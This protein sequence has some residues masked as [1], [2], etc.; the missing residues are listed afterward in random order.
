MLTAFGV[1][2]VKIYKSFAELYFII[3][4]LMNKNFSDERRN[5]P[6]ICLRTFPK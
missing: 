6:L 4:N 1:L 2:S 3:F 5:H